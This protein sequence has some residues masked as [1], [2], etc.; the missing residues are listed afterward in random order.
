MQVNFGKNREKGKKKTFLDKE[1]S[2]FIQKKK[3]I[4]L[5]PTISFFF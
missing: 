2:T 3:K 5:A 1:F 4:H